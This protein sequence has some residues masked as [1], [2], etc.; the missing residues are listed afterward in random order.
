MVYDFI[1]FHE[2]KPYSNPEVLKIEVQLNLNGRM[3]VYL[4][5][6]FQR[7][8]NGQSNDLKTL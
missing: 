6:W 5:V 8:Q 1:T 7:F 4:Q 3:T 2:A